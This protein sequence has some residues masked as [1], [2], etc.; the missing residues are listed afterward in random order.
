MK[1]FY[2]DTSIWLDF[3]EERNEPNR[4]KSE[5]AKKLITKIIGKADIIVYSD[6]ILRELENTGYSNFDVENLLFLLE[7]NLVFVES[8]NA[9]I[10]RAKDLAS[11]RSVPRKDALHALIARDNNAILVTLDRHFQSLNDIVKV[12]KPQEL[13][14]L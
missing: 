11:K 13:I 2:L 3:F 12:R 14:E 10:K 7:N 5:W 6:L 9:E 1:R 8:T 4:P